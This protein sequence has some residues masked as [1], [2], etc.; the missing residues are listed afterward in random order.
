MRDKNIRIAGAS[1]FWGDA[2]RATPQLLKGGNV[3]FIAYD[4]LAEITMSIMARARAKNPDYG[5]ALDFV[6]AAMKPN[7]KEIARQGVKIVSNAGGVNPQAC[8]KALRGVIAEQGLKLKVACV[9]GDDMIAQVDELA[10][11][12]HSEMFTGAAF[13]GADKIASINAYLGAFPVAKALEEG[14]DIVVTG[15]CVDSA[16]TLGACIHAFGWGREDLD[17]LAM[18]SLAGHIIECGPQATGGNFTDWEDVHNLA[19]IGYPITEISADGN[20]VCCKPEGTGGL[21]TTATIAEQMVYEIGDPQ[22]YMLPDVICDFSNV[23]LEQVGEDL[24]RVTGATGSPAPD[25]YKVCT[26]YADEFRG[27]TNMTFY[28]IDADRK[29]QKL[30]E[31]IFVAARRTLRQ[32]GLP[33]FSETS[34]E[35][36]GTESQYGSAA[37]V[38]NCREVV[39][40]IAAKHPDAAGI[41]IMLKETVGLGLA[42]PPGLSGFAGARPSPS[43]VVRLFSFALS[44][45]AAKVQVE[46]DGVIFDVPDTAGI[47]FNKQVI[48][49]PERPAIPTDNLVPVPLIKLAWGR[50]GDKGDKAN[51]GIIARQPEYLPYIYAAL[52]EQ[53]VFEKFAHF[54][55]DGATSD[56]MVERY[57]MPGTHAINFLI[58]DVLGGGGMASIRNDA[59]GKG[60]GQLLLAAS[61]PVSPE[62]ANKLNN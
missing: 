45:G 19:T 21:V 49:R 34:V 50:S 20:F 23:E 52:T 40:K 14:A 1:G 58:Q 27:G 51:I 7:L 26:T 32:L 17:K 59:Q 10:A 3:D 46:L 13:P 47:A 6:T 39:M 16:V 43:P 62:I 9:L 25:T 30:A 31:A 15:R 12:G 57:L 24:V 2:A 8:A 28:G 35:I 55:P 41:G 54:L 38:T 33:D 5:Y 60:Y 36:L 56:K 4:Y 18:G 29:A 61:I 37:T 53:A 42:T 11:Q 44:K 22:A 48:S